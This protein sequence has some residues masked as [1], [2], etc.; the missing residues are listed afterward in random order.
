MTKMRKIEGNRVIVLRSNAVSPDPRV[1]KIARTL[2]INGYTVS[3]LARNTSGDLP[4]AEE[5]PSYSILRLGVPSYPARGLGNL[6]S[7]LRWQFALW[8]WLVFH[9]AEYDLIH[10]CD[11]DTILPALW[12]R[13]FFNKKVI[14]DI[15]DYYADML[16]NTPV[17]LVRFVRWIERMAIGMADAVILADEARREQIRGS[18]PRKLAFIYNSPEDILDGARE[19]EKE[20]NVELR[21]AYIGNIQSERGIFELLEVISHHPSWRLDMGGFGPDVQKVVE[22]S[23]KLP[24]VVWHGLVPYETAIE[25]NRRADVLLATYD[26]CIPNN[27][28]SSPNKVFEAMML[29][30]PII[31]AKDTNADHLVNEAGCG[32]IVPYGDLNALEAALESLSNNPEVQRTFGRRGRE[33]YIKKY[34]WRIMQRRLLELYSSIQVAD[35]R[36]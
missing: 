19:T 7:M 18:N 31:V 22:Q 17:W 34:D 20:P 9:Q 4:S 10:A 35:K 5:K 27:R 21:I 36:P 2:S 11:F 16:R 3:V 28:Y 1:E 12:C 6:P 13:T 24:N 33:A 8:R 32:L 15:F 26:P 29:A 23:R 25:I 14:Y 30:K